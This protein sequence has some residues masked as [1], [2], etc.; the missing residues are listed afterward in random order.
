[1]FILKAIPSHPSADG[2]YAEYARPAIVT[3]TVR[4][5]KRK[6]YNSHRY[7]VD[8]RWIESMVGC[9]SPRMFR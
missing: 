4:K 3:P 1:M 7:A 8:H 6:P 5:P 2:P 9:S